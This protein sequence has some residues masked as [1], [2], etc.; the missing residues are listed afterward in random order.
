MK[1]KCINDGNY[2]NIT[3]GNE[4]EVVEEKRDLY[5]IINDIG[6]EANYHKKF[7]EKSKPIPPQK[8]K[9]VFSFD[10]ESDVLTIESGFPNQIRRDTVNFYPEEVAGN[11]GTT[12]IN[13]INSLCAQ[14]RQLEEETEENIEAAIDAIL[15]EQ[16]VAITVFSTNN[17]YP[18]LWNVLDRICNF[19]SE[20]RTNPNSDL[21]IKMW[22]FY[23]H[24]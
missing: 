3:T 13:G 14:L 18:L 22:G 19:C 2:N 12:S 7:F 16:S 17:Q 8:I 23:T 11:C 6:V 15:V 20:S 9:P 5:T 21:P 24:E 1:I 10:R 4:Y